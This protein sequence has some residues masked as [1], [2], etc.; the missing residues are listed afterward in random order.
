[1]SEIYISGLQLGGCH[2]SSDFSGVENH[3]GFLAL[4][5]TIRKLAATVGENEVENYWHFEVCDV[6]LRAGT[7]CFLCRDHTHFSSLSRTRG[8]TFL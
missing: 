5:V 3:E 2:S 1:M 7:K 4:A 8:E 6:F